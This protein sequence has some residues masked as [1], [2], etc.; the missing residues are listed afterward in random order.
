MWVL[1]RMGLILTFVLLTGCLG[2]GGGSGSDSGAPSPGNSAED[3]GETADEETPG[4]ACTFNG[5]IAGG[6]EQALVE[7]SRFG[8]SGWRSVGEPTRSDENG[9]F[10][11]ELTESSQPLRV[12]VSAT[13]ES[14]RRCDAP[15]G[16]DGV[17][18]GET[19]SP[20]GDFALSTIVPGE[21]ACP[22]QDDLLVV[23]PLT[24]MAATWAEQLPPSMTNAGAE[25]SLDRLRELL[26]MNGNPATM[27]LPA[28]N[29]DDALSE[30]GTGVRRHAYLTAAFDEL[31]QSSDWTFEDLTQG[32]GLMFSA[33]GGQLPI[34]PLDLEGGPV[35]QELT[36]LGLDPE[37]LWPGLETTAVTLP[38]L[39]TLLNAAVTV[40][41]SVRPGSDDSA[42]I[43]ALLDPWES[44]T[45]TALV[46]SA[47]HSQQA[48]D[49]AMT[50][51]N[52]VM[53]YREEAIA[54]GESVH[55]DHR[56]LG[57]LYADDQARDD[58]TAMV[59]VLAEAVG[60]AVQATLCVPE[61]KN[62]G[63]C[64]VAPPYATLVEDSGRTFWRSGSLV[65]EGE[66]LG[67]Q[68]SL[69]ASAEDIRELVTGEGKM[70]ISLE[71]SVTN[72]TAVLAMDLRLDLDL[73]EN[74]LS[75]FDELSTLEFADETVR[76]PL[77]EELLADLHARMTLTGGLSLNAVDSA[78]GEYRLSNIHTI[79]T[80]DRSVLTQGNPGPLLD[81]QLV[82]GE[83]HNPAGETL[84]TLAG[85]DGLRLI[86][87]E[88]IHFSTAYVSDRL[89]LPPIT[90]TASSD[91]DGGEELV[92]V[93]EDLLN[94]VLS[95]E[96]DL[97]TVDLDPLMAVLTPDLLD[98][99]GE[100]QVSVAD[101]ERGQQDYGIRRGAQG[102]L[103]ITAANSQS[104]ALVLHLPGLAGVITG[105]EDVL[106]TLHP[107]LLEDDWLLARV[108]GT[109][110]TIPPWQKSAEDDRLNNLLL[111]LESLFQ[112]LVPEEEPAA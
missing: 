109:S 5:M 19:F 102:G 94:T 56:G 4:V 58:T 64:D 67:Q 36:E 22:A 27:S 73:G 21:G 32:A 53:A 104:T 90:V 107:G 29:D 93:M 86:L 84:T 91:L 70:P 98:F 54:A 2:G 23:S 65:I 40:A 43:A 77:I 44:R 9:R 101:P 33:L 92:A 81:V 52:D 111:L 37:A 50:L 99:Q 7:A 26:A 15:A 8:D 3:P 35:A 18:Q 14:Q 96:G 80:V 88:G 100:A 63:S 105:E 110:E 25:L 106:G 82:S 16:C 79:V 45:L 78:I 51:V 24:T 17:A 13:A 38:G 95:E 55:P 97:T 112:A 49:Q 83:R 6:V 30:V 1:L 74:D 76:D 72:G 69:E 12:R 46:G 89:G 57:W 28:L 85:Q 103:A 71:G 10:A 60:M 61:R 62:G 41:E 48:L 59:E 39:E 20:H 66:R 34:A 75:G 31:A 47:P 68:V 108:D 42:Q 87:D 11:L